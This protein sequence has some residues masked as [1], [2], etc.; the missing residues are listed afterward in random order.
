MTASTTE[1]GRG[2]RY[3]EQ[4]R[5]GGKR[6]TDRD[7]RVLAEGHGAAVNRARRAWL[8]SPA[9]WARGVGR[10]ER[11]ARGRHVVPALPKDPAIGE[12]PFD[13]RHSGQ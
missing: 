8:A 11:G 5:R 12:A 9:T 1:L 3:T 13:R 4:L 7:A 6:T 10:A 2:E